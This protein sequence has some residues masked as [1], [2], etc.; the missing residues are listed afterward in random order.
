MFSHRGLQ[1]VFFIALYWGVALLALLAAVY[2][3]VHA[4]GDAAGAAERRGH[5]GLLTR[6]VC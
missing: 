1:D 2:L 4:R 5:E 3:A 6:N